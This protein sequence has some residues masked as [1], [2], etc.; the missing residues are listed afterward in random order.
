MQA[1]ERDERA[2]LYVFDMPIPVAVALVVLWTFACATVF[3]Y[4]TDEWSL[5]ETFYFFFISLR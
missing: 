5:L 1:I 3:S 4:L 2:S